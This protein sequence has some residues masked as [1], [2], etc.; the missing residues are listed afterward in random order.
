MPH[1]LQQLSYTSDSWK[2]LVAKPQNRIEAVRPAVEKLGGK[3][4]SAW[5]AFG[6]Y[7]IVL[8]VDMPDNV[9]AAAIAIALAAGGSLKS[10][11]TTPLLSAAEGLEAM[12]KAGGSGYR[13]M[14]S[15]A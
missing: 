15:R 7:D 12:K 6:E 13:A 1:F 4:E 3:I 5:F 10:F 9:S 8:I 11:K 2:T 14:K